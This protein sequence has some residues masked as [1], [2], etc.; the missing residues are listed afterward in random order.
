MQD[1]KA[2]QLKRIKYAQMQQIQLENQLLKIAKN[3]VNAQLSLNIYNNIAQNYKDI[4]TIN[5]PHKYLLNKALFLDIDKYKIKIINSINADKKMGERLTSNKGDFAD[6]Y[7]LVVPIFNKNYKGV[8]SLQFIDDTGNKLMLKGG[9]VFGNYFEIKSKELTNKYIIVEGV[10]DALALTQILNN[11]NI[12]VAFSAQLIKYVV[13]NIIADDK[14][15]QIIIFADYDAESKTGE[16]FA[17]ETIKEFGGNYIFPPDE[18]KDFCD[19]YTL[20]YKQTH[21][22]KQTLKIMQNY[23]FKELKKFL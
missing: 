4:Y 5:K 23:I 6:G 11:F 18:I 10:A 16:I 14:T 15:A 17:K 9:E 1:K 19:F 8:Y 12:V 21:N 13:K 2:K 3:D 7:W 20:I 22:K